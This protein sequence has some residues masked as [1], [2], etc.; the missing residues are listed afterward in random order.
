MSGVS[1]QV[2]AHVNRPHSFPLPGLWE[3]WVWMEVHVVV[4]VIEGVPWGCFC[5]R[6]IW[7][8]ERIRQVR[9]IRGVIMLP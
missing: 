6:F 8:I 5:L 4:G 1:V 9:V 2:L 3:F 7:L